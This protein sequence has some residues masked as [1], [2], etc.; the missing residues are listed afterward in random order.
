VN[1]GNIATNT[2]DIA[3]NTA[4]IAADTDGDATNELNTNVALN[5][6]SLDV[7]DAGGTLSAD[8]A[9]LQTTQGTTNAVDISNLQT[10][11]AGSTIS[12]TVLDANG[13]YT[14]TEGTV[15]HATD[16]TH[17]ITTQATSNAATIVHNAGGIVNGTTIKSNQDLTNKVQYVNVTANQTAVGNG[18]TINASNGTA[19]G[20]SAEVNAVGGTALGHGAI[21][22][23]GA[24]NSVAIG[25]NSVATEANSV[26]VGSVGDERKITNVAKGTNTTDAVNVGQLT[27]VGSQVDTNTRGISAN[28][29]RISANTQRIGAVEQRIQ[30]IN[31]DQSI[32][33][34]GKDAIATPVDS[35]ALGKSAEVQN[36]AKGSMALGANT[37]VTQ[38][39]E[40]SVALGQYSVANE[41]NTI[42]VGNDNFKR[43]ITNVAD[44]INDYDAVN[45]RQFNGLERKMSG[46]GAMNSAMSALVP[47]QRVTGDTQLSI[48]LGYYD[49]EAAIAGG[50]FHYINDDVLLN[51][52]VSYSRES[53]T[54]GRAGVTWGF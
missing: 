3:S 40:N 35:V 30:Y 8:L 27:A 23:A 32:T 6:T 18:A 36:G 53:G 37:T 33:A 2:T 17:L 24:T 45:M 42:S 25:Q 52:G 39:A 22:N 43:R 21:V 47:N 41:A 9:G 16:F 5:G 38:N 51:A 54:A 28:S 48:G 20:Q 11:V 26:S 49:S 7:T 44:G 50:M 29:G 12:N 31:I 46:I 19:I 1:A 13:I 15:D 4:A 14:I 10:G 34:L